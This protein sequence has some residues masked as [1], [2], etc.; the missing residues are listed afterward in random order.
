MPADKWSLI[1]H[2]T[3]KKNSQMR[4]LFYTFM[5]SGLLS[6]T[7]SAQEK[8]YTSSCI[9]FYNL[10]N[11][12]DTLDQEGVR[13]GEFTPGSAK[14]W[15][16]ERYTKKLGDLSRV[17]GELG[18]ELHPNG[19]AIL[20]VSEVE[21]RSVLE[22]LV[23][24]EAIAKRNYQIIH[25]D[26]PDRRGIDVGLLYDSTRFKVTSHQAFF[27]DLGLND[28]GDTIYSRDQLLVSGVLEGEPIHVI[29][30]HWP[31]RSGGQKRSNPR[32]IKAGQLGRT[33]IDSLQQADPNAAIVYMGDLN[34]D[35]TDPSVRR[36]LRSSGDKVMAT[37]G[38]LY[39]PMVEYARKGIG[40]LAWRD[41]W[42]LFDQVI[43]SENLLDESGLRYYGTRVYNEP[44]LRQKEG[45]WAGYPFR[46]YVGST[47]QG[48]FS[49]HF[50][51]FVIL[52][53]EVKY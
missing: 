37:N 21:N 43:L 27:L 36:F 22:D 10:E 40:S 32:R 24:T 44:Y 48:G 46:T 20:G 9:G 53:K 34:D 33:I 35:P 6:Y 4:Q 52:V 26:S 7:L 47:Y 11:L 12:F 14:L 5:L 38:K 1:W 16:K 45:N 39:N 31:S 2:P 49:D 13:D 29:V 50:P 41:S 8:Q 42:N 19:L 18:A 28:K 23:R 3:C 25:H 15:G 51:V 17:I 30:A